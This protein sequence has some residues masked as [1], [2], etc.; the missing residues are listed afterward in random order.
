MCFS[1][2][3]Y[4]IFLLGGILDYFIEELVLELAL[5]NELKLSNKEGLEN[6]PPRSVL[7]KNVQ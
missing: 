2:L 7:L 1:I 4:F 5:N 6:F 3:F